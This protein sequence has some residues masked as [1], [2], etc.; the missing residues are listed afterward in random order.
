M[1]L[2]AS[3]VATDTLVPRPDRR[4]QSPARHQSSQAAPGPLNTDSL[5]ALQRS[6]GN[7]A[8]RELLLVQRTQDDA[9]KYARRMRIM[10]GTVI[11]PESVEAFLQ[12]P[13]NHRS[14]P[15]PL[16]K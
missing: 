5:L 7:R 3:R 6:A 10:R 4:P 15:Q 2:H 11:T 13:P 14:D 16:L 9:K 12:N 8:T 1:L